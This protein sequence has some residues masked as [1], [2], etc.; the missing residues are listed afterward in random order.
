MPLDEKTKKR[1]LKRL[2]TEYARVPT[3]EDH[4][5]VKGSQVPLTINFNIFGM[6][7]QEDNL[8]FLLHI[9]QVSGPEHLAEGL[10]SYLE[11]TLRGWVQPDLPELEEVEMKLYG[12]NNLDAV[13]RG[14]DWTPEPQESN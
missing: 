2:R 4:T 9:M 3:W 1:I 11:D 12:F 10:I 14:A 8:V 13:T 5:V 7:W 6:Y